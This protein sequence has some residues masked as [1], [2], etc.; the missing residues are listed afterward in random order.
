LKGYRRTFVIFRKQDLKPVVEH[1][2]FNLGSVSEI[3]DRNGNAKQ[4]Q[5][6]SKMPLR[7]DGSS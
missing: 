2:L 1:K 3:N 4:Y 6:Q 7:H 5:E